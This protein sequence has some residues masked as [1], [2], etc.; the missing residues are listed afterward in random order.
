MRQKVLGKTQGES[1]Y[2]H[3]S[4]DDSGTS[5]ALTE[6]DDAKIAW[7]EMKTVTLNSELA[8]EKQIKGIKI[9]VEGFEGDVL[10]GASHLLFNG[11][12]R[13]W[14]VEC[15]GHCWNRNKD[16]LNSVRRLMSEYGLD[17]FVLDGNGGFPK[18]YPPNVY[19]YSNIIP[20]LLFAKL[21][22]LNEDWVLDDVSKL[23]VPYSPNFEQGS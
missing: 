20:N 2:F 19:I 9:D 1:V 12:V 10:R 8:N 3:F 21:E 17:M 18:L 6:K 14:I 11:S 15:A 16:D 7:E 22:H 13:Y 5:Y 4:T 23:V